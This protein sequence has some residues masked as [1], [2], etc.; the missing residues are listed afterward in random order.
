MPGERKE[1]PE[2]KLSQSFRR[3]VDNMHGQDKTY[4]WGCKLFSDTPSYKWDT[5]EEDDDED[6]VEH[7]LQ[8]K[9]LVLGAEATISERNIV[10]IETKSFDGEDLQLVIGCLE[11]GKTEN[12]AVDLTFTNEI[13]VTFRLV[14]G[15]GP[16]HLI[17]QHTVEFPEAEGSEADTADE[18][19]DSEEGVP[20]VGAKRKSSD[21]SDGKVKAKRRRQEMPSTATEDSEDS[22]DSDEAMTGGAD[23]EGT[24][25][26]EEEDIEESD[27][28]E[29][30]EDPKPK[31]KSRKTGKAKANGNSNAATKKKQKKVIT[32][33]KLAG[34]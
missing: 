29:E 21:T 27:D 23:T 22:D 28:A 5:S 1:R 2:S 17:A 14:H 3:I 31:R 13:P 26:D 18:T 11:V 10:A 7:T 32:L 15:A 19:C 8:L 16:V 30:E 33:Y 9:Q 24:G 34:K 6:F 25:E 4:I 20:D 12:Q